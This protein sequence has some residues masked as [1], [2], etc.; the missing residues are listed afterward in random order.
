ML[1][2]LVVASMNV[3]AGPQ[4]DSGFVAHEWGTFTSVQG[5]DAVQLEWSPLVSSELPKFVYNCNSAGKKPGRSFD[6]KSSFLT[7]QRME[8]PVIYFYS[9]QARKVDVTVQ[10]PQGTVTE[11][12]P[13][14]ATLTKSK[15]DLQLEQQ[16]GLRWSNV[17]ILGEKQ[18]AQSMPVDK[19]GSHYFAARN[20]D[21]NLLKVINPGTGKEE[22]DKFLFYRGVGSFRAP[23]QAGLDTLENNVL[24]SNTGKEELRNFYVLRI[25]KGIGR[26]IYLDRLAPGASATVKLP[27]RDAFLRL[28]DLQDRICSEM[29]NSLTE[30]GL[31][32]AEA[33]AMVA[34]WRDS[35]FG[36]DGIRVLY[37]L[38]RVWADR[39]LPLKVQPPPAETVRVMVGR[40]EILQPSKEW[41]L[42]KQ[43][44]R[45]SESESGARPQVVQTT[46]E[47]GLGRFTE[48]AIRHVTSRLPNREFGEFAWALLNATRPE[49]AEG[50]PL[51]SK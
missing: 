40:A 45:Y 28:S 27:Q 51:A 46:R 15:E 12:F 43:V 13:Q 24:L 38:P 6:V 19:S 4:Q 31:Y 5:S 39:V 7:L 34:T 1:S 29:A 10:F 48:A 8:T 25:E 26:F 11:W 9:D 47:I 50:K 42:L 17:E 20:T 37:T 35:W 16:H 21:A 30:Q 44:V 22:Y 2:I 36:E 3:L 18:G 41:Q 14:V 23:L 32:P 33:K 49:S